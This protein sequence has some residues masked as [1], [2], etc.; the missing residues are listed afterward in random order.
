[1]LEPG[2]LLVLDVRDWDASAARYE[3]DPIVE[4]GAVVPGGTLTFRSETRLRPA[5][6]TL[7]IHERVALD[8]RAEE[9]EF[10]MR[11]WT[12]AE[13]RQRAADRIVAVAAIPRTEPAG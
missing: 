8:A 3:A 4:R 10:A 2:G 5:D 9:F 6:R 1:M 12:P 7:L 11:C 13:L